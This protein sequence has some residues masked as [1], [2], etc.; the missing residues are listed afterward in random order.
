MYIGDSNFKFSSNQTVAGLK[1]NYYPSARCITT[2]FKS[3]RCGI[4]TYD[5]PSSNS[6]RS[7]F[8]SDRCGIETLFDLALKIM[9]IRSNQTVAGLKPE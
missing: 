4:E 1:P 9:R 2:A 5:T 8:K 7:E 6:G 3:D